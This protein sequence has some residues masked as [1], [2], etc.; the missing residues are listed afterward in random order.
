MAR[1]EHTP[2]VHITAMW[3]YLTVFAAL[4]AGT[5]L[6]VVASRLDLG[7]WNTPIALIIATIKALLVILF[8]NRRSILAGLRRWRQN[9]MVILAVGAFLSISVILSA[10]GNFGLL[11]RQRTQVLPFLF[12]LPCMVKIPGRRRPEERPTP[13]PGS[14]TVA[15]DGV[16]AAP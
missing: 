5:I 11:A 15:A 12:M 8:V 6:T 7:I 2:H 9:G 3:I 4:A 16:P 13:R 1:Q 14:E 10:L